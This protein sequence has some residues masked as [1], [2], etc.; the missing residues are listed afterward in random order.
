[1]PANKTSE[2]IT[3]G[4]GVTA[5]ERK[6]AEIGDK[7]FLKLWSYPN[8]YI[9]KKQHEKGTGKEFCDL[10]VICGDDVIIFSDKCIE[11]PSKA[12]D[13]NIS[14]SRWYRRAIESSVAQIKGAARWI[15]QYPDRVF[16]DAECTK[17]LPIKF[18]P[19]DRIRIHGV[20]VAMGANKA[21]ANYF[22]D[23][24]GTFLIASALKGRGHISPDN[25]PFYHPFTIGDVDPSGPF[26]HVFDTVSLD[27]LFNDLNTVTDFTEYLSK[28]SELIRNE[29]LTVAYGEEDLLA[30]YLKSVGPDG[31]HAFTDG[32]GNLLGEN[33]FLVIEDGTYEHY[34]ASKQ[35]AAKKDADA[36]SFF[37]DDLIGRFTKHLMAGTTYAFEGEPSSAETVEPGLR[38]M[39]RVNRVERRL[40]SQT[41]IEAMQKAEELKTERYFR[42]FFP[43]ERNIDKDT[44]YVLLILSFPPFLSG[45][46][47]HRKY[48]TVRAEFLQIYCLAVLRQYQNIKQ[49][50]GI[51]L[52]ASPKVTGRTGSSE[53]MIVVSDVKWTDELIEELEN[54]KKEYD[55]L[56]GN[57]S[58]I[59]YVEVDE[60]PNNIASSTA[61]PGL[62]RQQRRR[63]ERQMRKGRF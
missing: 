6:L 5:S 33:Q 47:G 48:R 11:W 27:V 3:K 62:S 40:L 37:W 57:E 58:K 9:D 12:E 39:A 35:Y 21:C 4:E 2:A 59:S 49:V 54:S 7:T 29:K 10:L 20:A 56:Q 53:D 25:K 38:I 31:Q 36:I 41:F 17:R 18:P 60:Y 1:M 8:T 30:H 51:G 50:V 24:N 26:V 42:T 46:S 19:P 23:L 45:E 15:A 61:P 63:M 43:G 28:R 22:G 52:D 44:A 55:I 34:I 32:K 13:I 14:W 16:L